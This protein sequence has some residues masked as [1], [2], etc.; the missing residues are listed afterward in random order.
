MIIIADD[1]RECSTLTFAILFLRE[2]YVLMKCGVCKGATPQKIRLQ[3]L[4]RKKR[5]KKR[6]NI[7]VDWN[8]TTSAVKCGERRYY[9]E[10]S[11]A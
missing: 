8:L 5:E 1:K 9:S 2:K 10:G 7:N 6:R 3:R 11:R 4:F